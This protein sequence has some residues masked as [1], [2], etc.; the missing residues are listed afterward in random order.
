MLNSLKIFLVFFS[1]LLFTTLNAKSIEFS[2][3]SQTLL[4]E[5]KI[6]IDKDDVNFSQIKSD[7]IFTSYGQKHINLGFV[8]NTTLW[9]KLEFHNSSHKRVSKILEVQNPLLEDVF[10]YQN[11]TPIKKGSSHV[12]KHK[13]SI[14]TVFDLSLNANETRVCYLKITNATTALRLGLSLQDKALFVEEEHH[15]ELLIY[16]FF[17]IVLMLF[18]YNTFLYLYT[19][20]N[21]YAYY[22]LYLLA[23]MSQQSTYLGLTQ[24]Y[25]PQWFINY[26]NL[27]VL[28]KVNIMYITAA[29]FA[30]SF[31]QTKKYPLLN[32]TYNIFITLSLLEIPIFGT[33]YFYYPEVGIVTA[34]VFI[35]FNMCAGFYIYRQGNKQARLFVIGWSFLVVGFVLMIVDALGIISVMQN[36]SNLIMFLLALEAMVLSLA[37]M[38]RYII[39][40][41]EK[42]NADALLVS[43]YESR[44][45]VIEAKIKEQTVSLSKALQTKEVLLRELHHRTK[46]NL[47]LITSLVRMQADGLQEYEKGKFYDLERRINAISKTHQMLYLK[48][49]LQSID[50]CLYIS[51][52]YED[53]VELSN[54]N[55]DAK[56]DISNVFMPLREAS[57]IG[58][59]VNELIT[60]SMKYVQKE[61]IKIEIF[62]S[63]EE[64]K[65]HLTIKDNGD[66]VEYKELKKDGLGIKLVRTLVE[67]QL[68]GTLKIEIKDGLKYMIEFAL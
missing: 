29:L 31:L 61:E 12:G 56:I 50:M 37:F 48:E 45:V 8:R 36:I 1:L 54:K 41:S 13:N 32:K 53:I 22:S 60:N 4:Q 5:T 14:N 59:I 47:Q 35:V 24:M 62:F 17:T 16:I 34:L 10:L 65:Y 57:Y 63:Y 15:R 68:E 39:L 30:K 19:K 25:M 21:M 58:L 7:A 40:R 44:Q 3:N 38:D 23:L 26:D 49:D 11:Q 28:L 27:N 43:E 18:T 33:P 20:E 52:L 2:Q 46:N 67:S 55:I 6:Y 51:E 64:E 9:I 42:Q 66:S